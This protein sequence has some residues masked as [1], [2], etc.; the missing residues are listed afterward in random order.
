MAKNAKSTKKNA[1]S[2]SKKENAKAVKNSVK[3][4]EKK[5]EEVVK[6]KV[7]IERATKWLY[8]ADCTTIKDRKSFRTQARNKIASWDKK[9]SEKIDSKGVKFSS[10][11]LK[12]FRTSKED[13]IAKHVNKE[14]RAAKQWV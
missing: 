11:E 2:T 3:K 12:G 7:I 14:Y 13:F 9:L 6:G 10:K 1:K 8:P 5:T 4:A